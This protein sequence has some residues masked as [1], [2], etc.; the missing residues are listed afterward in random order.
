[1]FNLENVIKNTSP[2]KNHSKKATKQIFFIE[3]KLKELFARDL[4]YEK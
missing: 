2:K 4:Q 3:T 1:M